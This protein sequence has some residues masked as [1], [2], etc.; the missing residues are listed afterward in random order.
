MEKRNEQLSYTKFSEYDFCRTIHHDIFLYYNQP[1]A[2]HL[3]FILFWKNTLHVSGD[4]SDHHQESKT[5]HTASSV[6][7]SGSVAAC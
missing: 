1:D 4:L 2:K 5:V 6:C 3:K 7:H